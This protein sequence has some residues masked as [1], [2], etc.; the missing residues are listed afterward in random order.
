MRH[1]EFRDEPGWNA[2]QKVRHQGT[3][4]SNPLAAAAGLACLQKCADSAIQARC[5]DLASGLR[6][7][8]NGVLE[9]RGLPGFVWGSSSVF[10]VGLG[11][12]CANRTS[13]DLQAPTGLPAD[14]LKASAQGPLAGPL[15]Q[16]MLLEGVDFF[17]SGGLLSVA[18]RDADIATTVGA[19]DRVLGRME[20]E[21]LFG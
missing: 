4:N 14:K 17:A 15:Q 8:L 19:F 20:R 10:H 7:G 2:T 6:A 3:Y 16:G 1:L 21:G 12:T 9:R 18:H 13:G 11:E 5:D